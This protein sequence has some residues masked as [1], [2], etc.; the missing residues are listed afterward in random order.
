MVSGV[1]CYASH[2]R[3]PDAATPDAGTVLAACLPNGGVA[4]E[5][6]PDRTD[7]RYR[8][9]RGE[10]VSGG[11]TIEVCV[12]APSACQPYVELGCRG[13]RPAT[14]PPGLECAY[15]VPR[16]D[17]GGYCLHPCEGDD[18]CPERT[19]CF[20]VSDVMDHPFDMPRA[21]FAVL[22]D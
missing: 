4:G 13:S 11:E 6:P 14:D 1:G 3:E 17:G 18:D 15:T 21:C 19:R 9:V 5:C 10:V 8:I 20:D 2:E 16:N 7:R 22:E 12:C